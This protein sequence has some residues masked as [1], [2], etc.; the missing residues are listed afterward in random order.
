MTKKLKLLSKICIGLCLILFAS[1]EKD[2]YDEHLHQEKI[3]STI[4]LD[5]FKKETGF[6]D[7]STSVNIKHNISN[8]QRTSNGSYEFD[9][10]II[11]TKTI[12]KVVI[13]Q[14][15]TYTFQ[16]VPKDI[17]NDRYFNIIYYYKN[18][19]QS[20]ILEIKPTPE[21][22]LN[23]K[24]GTTNKLEGSIRKIYQSNKYQTFFDCNDIVLL[25]Q[26][27]TGCTGSCDECSIC[28]YHITISICGG[29]AGV[30]Y[31][32]AGGSTGGNSSDAGGGAHGDA[33][34]SAPSDNEIQVAPVLN[35]TYL[36]GQQHEKTPCSELY[37]YITNNSIQQS[38]R[39][40]KQQSSGNAEYGN[41][42]CETTNTAGATYLSF[43]IIPQDPKNPSQIDIKAGLANGNV[44][45][46]M[47]CHT[48]P[49]STTMFPMFSTADLGCL[50]QIAF[51][52]IPVNNAPKEYAE[53]TVMLSVGSGHYSLKFKNFNGDY[54]AK[55]NANLADFKKYLESE[56]LEL[57]PMADSTLLIKAFLKN[58]NKYFGNEIGMYK[59]TEGT[60]ANG[61][62][63]IT[64][65]KEQ[66]LNE[67]GDVI[68]IDCQ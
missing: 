27:C 24:A 8:A 9:D 57:T 3:K 52:N 50:Y 53:Y 25:I 48:D 23:R 40:L 46:A 32:N 44:K 45:G 62:P 7:F 33:S 29:N 15:T 43:P 65:W 19:W 59:A 30:F 42:I 55:L 36:E 5:Q 58:L 11:D 12:N 14:K 37:K 18:G 10:F 1:C 63:N 51:Q 2:L 26:N 13:N 28:Q 35:N 38:L 34:G 47:H 61:L 31:V 20:Q 64:G 60:D 17:V 41:F 68:E 49:A 66:V 54:E 21:N 56:N 16:L 6:K 39:I 4:S 22:L 67:V